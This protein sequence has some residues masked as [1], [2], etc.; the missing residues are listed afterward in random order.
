MVPYGLLT[1]LCYYTVSRLYCLKATTKQTKLREKKKKN[2]WRNW[3]EARNE[4][5]YYLLL[6]AHIYASMLF[7]RSCLVRTRCWR[8]LHIFVFVISTQYT[9]GPTDQT[10]QIIFWFLFTFFF[11]S[12]LFVSSRLKIAVVLFL[13]CQCVKIEWMCELREMRMN[14]LSAHVILFFLY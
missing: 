1:Q 6:S 3:S 4:I 9:C 12:F 8:H 5:A 7:V 2:R 10:R 11:S 13:L 14:L